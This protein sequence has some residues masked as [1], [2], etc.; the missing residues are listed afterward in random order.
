MV[1]D[2]LLDAAHVDRFKTLILPNI[3]AL[4]TQQCDQIR[5]YVDRGGGVVATHETSLY[6][7]K[8][9]RRDNFG[10]SDLFGASFDGRIEA[11]MQN[12]YLPLAPDPAPGTRHPIL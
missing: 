4:S 5:G 10:L 8:G 6:D 2:H 11:R 9:V 12:S 1:H 7:E 3:A